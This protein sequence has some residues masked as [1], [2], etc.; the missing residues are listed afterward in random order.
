M[1]TDEQNNQNQTNQ[2]GTPG[3]DSGNT[4]QN[5]NQNNNQNQM[6]AW[7]TAIYES[8][9]LRQEAETRAANAERALSQRTEE[10]NNSQIKLD[11]N[12]MLN[13][14]EKF[15]AR[16]NQDIQRQTAPLNEF[17]A[18]QR[19]QQEYVMNKNRVRMTNPNIAPAFPIGGPI[20]QQLDQAFLSQPNFDI[21]ENG[22]FLKITSMVGTLLL[23]GA[24]NNNQNNNNNQNQNQNQNNNQNN[25]SNNNQNNQNN[26]MPPHLRPS[27]TAIHQNNN[28]QNVQLNE[29]ERRIARESGMTN[30]EFAT[31]RDT[32]PNKA[33]AAWNE[34]IAARKANNN[35]GGK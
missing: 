33:E 13:E 23:S 25:N 31:M 18:Q 26:M 27:G 3:N 7:Q 8:N 19:K 12:V 30:E 35:K 20:E 9:R 21:S 16:I 11:P 14:P 32:P 24:L 5:N 22:I 1:E 15:A 28:N 17:V 4:N 34:I 6:P 29:N 2:Q 10:T